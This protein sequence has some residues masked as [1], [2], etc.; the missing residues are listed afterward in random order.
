[1]KK[2]VLILSLLLSLI[3]SFTANSSNVGK[4]SVIDELDDYIG[5][6][7]VVGKSAL[8]NQH[9][10]VI[11]RTIA[12]N[13][14]GD[15]G[16]G[17]ATMI[18]TDMALDRSTRYVKMNR[19]HFDEGELEIEHQN[20]GHQVSSGQ[21]GG[22]ATIGMAV[23]METP[24]PIPAYHDRAQP[25]GTWGGRAATE[26][27][28]F[29]GV[30]NIFEVP[31]ENGISLTQFKVA[32][33]RDSIVHLV[34]GESFSEAGQRKQLLYTRLR[35]NLANRTFEIINPDE[36]PEMVTDLTFTSAGNIAVSPSGERVAIS[37]AISRYELG[38]SDTSAGSDL[39]IW[40][41]ED[42]GLDWDFDNSM[43]NVTQFQGPDLEL[44][45]DTTASEVDTLRSS[46]GNS[47]FFDEEDYLHV[48][49]ETNRYYYVDNTGYIYSQIY[50]WNEED[51]EY[52]R[53]ADGDF[54]LNAGVTTYGLV[55]GMPS[56]YKDPDTGFLWCLYQ[57][58]GEPGDTLEDGTA[59]DAGEESGRLN[60]DLYI[61]ASPPGEFN[62]RLWYKGVNITNTKGTTGNI[63]IGDCR[64]ERDA[65]L[66][67]NNDGDYLH[68][69]YL[70]DLNAGNHDNASEYSITDN[71]LVYQR[72][73]KQELID[74]YLENEEF[75][76][77]L[78]MHVDETG[79]WED[80]LNWAWRDIYDSAPEGKTLTPDD[81]AINSVYPNPFNSMARI[82]FTLKSAGKVELKVYDV[83]G[84]ELTTLINRT[85][86]FGRH[87][88]QLNADDF[89]SGI[90]F[91]TLESGNYQT[92]KKVVLIR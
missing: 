20:G 24:I 58:F 74:L 12:Y 54:Y 65:S 9:N 82:T 21:F 22:Y 85:L 28:Q 69:S 44:L 63:A 5:D 51:E 30:F 64:H 61:T 75:V 6:T 77:G 67:L 86:E 41:N 45:P 62:G 46:S 14:F 29:P 57:Q 59:M 60:A 32:V 16:A 8:D 90:Y 87:E 89:A 50:Y 33:D 1:M 79:H 27:S 47:M 17:V 19:I 84:R 73:S 71:P 68:V 3:F 7:L 23:N 78:P 25:G 72:V 10:V 37:R 55:A 80:E 13:P 35:H 92:V 76:T 39:I 11:G 42:R 83:L 48:A 4:S 56:L 91:I 88:V 38:L 31:Y 81:F 26:I 52:I 49:F 40:L 34:G 18:F 53:I 15:D 70:L 2:T 43:I 36:M 66:A